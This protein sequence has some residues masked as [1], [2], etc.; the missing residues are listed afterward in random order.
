LR[1]S[2]VEYKKD[3]S[4]LLLNDDGLRMGQ[5]PGVKV[6]LAEIS[7][8]WSILDVTNGLHAR[9]TLVFSGFFP[10]H[11]TKFYEASKISLNMI[12]G[13]KSCMNKHQLIYSK[14]SFYVSDLPSNQLDYHY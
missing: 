1:L 14:G 6:P 9:P 3:L 12:I 13:N 4:D 11:L 5:H 2:L 8:F 10:H 7:A